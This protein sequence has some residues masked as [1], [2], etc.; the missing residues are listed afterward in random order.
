MVLPQIAIG[1]GAASFWRGCWYI[2]DDHCYP[3]HPQASAAVCLGAGSLGTY[4][5]T[6]HVGQPYLR[7]GGLAVSCVLLWRGTWIASDQVYEAVWKA[8]ATDAGH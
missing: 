4:V 8:S 2:L 3:N 7:L 1:V 5:F 6:E